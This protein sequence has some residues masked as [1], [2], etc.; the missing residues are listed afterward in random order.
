M[1]SIANLSTLNFFFPFWCGICVSLCSTFFFFSDG[2]QSQIWVS[3]SV[4]IHSPRCNSSWCSASWK[5]YPVKAQ[6]SSDHFPWGD[7]WVLYGDTLAWSTLVSVAL[8]LVSQ[9]VS[10]HL[11]FIWTHRLRDTDSD[12][13]SS[14]VFIL[15]RTL[16]FTPHFPFFL[17]Y[18]LPCVLILCTFKIH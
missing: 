18:F 13:L 3:S 14:S 16:S 8:S 5:Y 4:R 6:L 17:V 2:S 11:D 9:S 15:F 1:I 12:L 7:V 10:F